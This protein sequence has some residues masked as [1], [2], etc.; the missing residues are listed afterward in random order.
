MPS[1]TDDA[2]ARIDQAIQEWKRIALNETNDIVGWRDAASD[3]YQYEGDPTRQWEDLDPDFN[4]LTVQLARWMATH[5]SS[6]DPTPLWD[7]Y[8]AAVVWHEEHT[9]RRLPRNEELGQK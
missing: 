7:F 5:H 3:R 6:M 4:S 2:D 1:F 9:A 8:E